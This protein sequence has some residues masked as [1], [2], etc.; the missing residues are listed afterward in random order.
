[1]YYRIVKQAGLHLKCRTDLINSC[2]PV[3]F[4]KAATDPSFWILLIANCYLVYKYER[5]PAIF[6]TLVWLYWSQSVIYGFFTFLIISGM[7]DPGINVREPTTAA[8]TSKLKGKITYSDLTAWFFVFHYGFFHLVY[9]IFL[10]TI[11]KLSL[12]NWQFFKYYLLVFF[13]AQLA[14]FIEHKLKKQK[15]QA[16]FGRALAIPYLRVIPM[17]LCILI[18]AFLNVLSLT[19]FLVFKVVADTVMY[20]VTNSN[21]QKNN[22]GDITALNTKSTTMPD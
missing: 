13:A 5:S 3:K 20:V 22:L 9:F 7:P 19:V 1:M 14:N 16:D 15:A 12:F 17:H 4:K 21:Y 18:P 6:S 2:L 8:M 10:L 11:T